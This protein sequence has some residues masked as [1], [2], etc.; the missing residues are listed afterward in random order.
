[1]THGNSANAARHSF[2]VRS[3]AVIAV[4]GVVALAILSGVVIF[5]SNPDGAVRIEIDDPAIQVTFAD[6]TFTID[7]NG[8]EIEVPPGQL[9]L[10]VKRGLL[11]FD[12]DKL[13]IT[14]RSDVALKVTWLDGELAVLRKEKKIGSKRQDATPPPAS[15]P[16]NAERAKQHQAAWAKHLGR[17]V[18]TTNSIGMK[19]RLIPPGKFLMGTSKEVLEEMISK[20]KE[21][22]Q[23]IPYVHRFPREIPQHKVRITKPFLLST[24][25]VT[26]GQFRQFVEAT[27]YKTD[28]EKD[29]K[30][31]KGFIDGRSS[32]RFL[33][34]TDL[35]FPQTDDH[36]VVNV[37]W[38]DA[39]A[40]AEWLSNQEGHSYRLPTEAEWEFACRAGTSGRWSVPTEMEPSLEDYAWVK[41]GGS[42]REAGTRPV[43]QKKAN[44]FGLHDMHGNVWEYCQDWLGAYSASPASD[45]TGSI[46]GSSR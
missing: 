37:S 31:G 41:R 20:A 40:F 19:M 9:K 10:Q 24:C 17:K 26:R 6:Q 7:D 39:V 18:E 30:G 45:P 14:K 16:F 42:R 28:A 5:F 8:R 15:A 21:K 33:W 22:R 36:P 25:E 1:M 32:T 46:A 44:P 3:G 38:N 23:T 35:E 11:E 29:G 27:S 34:N 2:P 43:G 4:A 12:T 13:T